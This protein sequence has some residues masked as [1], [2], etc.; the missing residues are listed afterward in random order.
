MGG[1]VNDWL[2]ILVVAPVTITLFGAYMA[3]VFA[4]VPYLL[5]LL[6]SAL[7]GLV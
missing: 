6:W 1:A 5:Y 2:A 7:Y 4:G 3:L